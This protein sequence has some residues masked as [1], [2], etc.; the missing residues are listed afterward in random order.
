MV[1]T[2]E[3]YTI[4][5]TGQNYSNQLKLIESIEKQI[6]IKFPK[7][8]NVLVNMTWFGPQF[9][10]PAYYQ[11]CDYYANNSIDNL[12]L[13][14][15]E[16]PS[17]FNIEETQKLISDSGAKQHYL[18]GNFNQGLHSFQFYATT[19]A[20]YF[21]KYTEED[22][23]LKTSKY[24]YLNYNRKPHDHRIKFV[25]MLDSKNL[26]AAGI[27]TLGNDRTLGETI[28]IEGNWN[29][30]DEYGIPH[31]ISTLGNLDIWQ[32]HF[33]NVVSETDFE[34]H[35]YT[36]M[37][38][39][40]WKPI[41]GLRPFVINGQLDVHQQLHE[42]GFK[43]FN[44]YWPHINLETCNMDDIHKNICD[45]IQWLQT[46]NLNQMYL[47]M[48]PDLRYNKLRFNEFVLEQQN[49]MENLFA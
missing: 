36:F 20:E 44:H 39:K 8:N 5:K 31:D 18:L 1:H 3:W 46:Q 7:Q 24:T 40:T 30:P 33:L 47:D 32:H 11:F 38:E 26:S 25:N 21:P 28:D 9:D 37:S 12:F 23:L 48:L 14:A 45:L 29:L 42:H 19:T 41:C 6:D 43:T 13:L 15:S 35:R 49:K 10:F 4:S 16:D 17:I 27:V 22:L 34:D 2:V